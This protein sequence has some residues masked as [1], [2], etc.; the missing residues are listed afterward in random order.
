M[1]ETRLRAD[2]AHGAV[3]RSEL[4]RLGCARAGNRGG[5][6]P[7]A[8]FAGAILTGAITEANTKEVDGAKGTWH[9]AAS[10]FFKQ[11]GI[12]LEAV[13]RAPLSDP[14]TVRPN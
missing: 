6:P 11:D 7:A 9:P 13:Y 14:G 5:G 2:R 8:A 10:D 3:L 1:P 4:A 12:V